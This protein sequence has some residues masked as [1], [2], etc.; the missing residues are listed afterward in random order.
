MANI[1]QDAEPQDDQ[2]DL[3]MEATYQYV[4]L[5]V[6]LLIA[7]LSAGVLIYL[8]GSGN[9]LGSVSAYYY[10]PARASFV[11]ALCALGGCLMIYR[12]N[13]DLEDLALNYAGLTS[14][15]VALVPTPLSCAASEADNV[16]QASGPCQLG[17]VPTAVQI[18]DA[19]QNNLWA[20]V[21]TG[22][23]L[24]LALLLL[25]RRSGAN[26]GRVIRRA[27]SGGLFV[28]LAL[29]VAGLTRNYDFLATW[30]HVTAAIVLCVT[31]IAVIAMNGVWLGAFT[32]LAEKLHL[33]RGA[34]A[35]P[36]FR[37][38]YTAIA[39]FMALATVVLGVVA[40][41][42]SFDHTIFVLEAI[43][44]LSFLVFWIVQSV[45]LWDVTDRSELPADPP[46]AA[47]ADR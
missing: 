5:A 21:A 29:L 32:R 42:G 14:F 38:T 28:A 2:H 10:T 18:R 11:V 22:A 3:D 45:E 41:M 46:A 37:G 39:W 25:S 9:W 43:I 34:E 19:V 12:G 33:T 13:S 17:N 7:M 24:L 20:L 4:R 16:V 47:R 8:L 44:F 15:V 40:V 36:G 31:L 30:A 6:P 23:L 35:A 1:V 27:T 26:P